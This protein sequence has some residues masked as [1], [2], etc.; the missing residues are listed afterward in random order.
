[1]GTEHDTSA[2]AVQ[3]IRRW[4]FSMGRA[5]YPKAR[6]LTITADGGSS[7]GYRVRLWKLELSRLAQETGLR[8]GVSHFPPGT[9]K[10]NQ[11]EHRLFSF[12]TM[13]WRGRPLISHEVI[14]NLIANTKTRS[15]LKVRSELDTNSYPKGLVVSDADFS[16]IKIEP[17]EFHAEWNYSI[18]PG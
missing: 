13:S 7:N 17:N 4:W 5:R 9:S 18:R 6:E 11:I 14:V 8:I 12:I 3:T 2:F 1:M 16:A 15:G 10:W